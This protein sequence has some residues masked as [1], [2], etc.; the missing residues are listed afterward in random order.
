MT[1]FERPPDS[2][3]RIFGIPYEG[4]GRVVIRATSGQSDEVPML[5]Y[6]KRVELDAELVEID[7]AQQIGLETGSRHNVGTRTSRA[8]HALRRVPI[9]RQEASFGLGLCDPEVVLSLEK[10]AARNNDLD[11]L[12]SRRVGVA[13]VVPQ[14]ID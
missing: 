13:E 2:S 5:P 7:R 9:V 6:K 11:E 14:T 8:Y 3:R 10:L 12:A 4:A 1:S